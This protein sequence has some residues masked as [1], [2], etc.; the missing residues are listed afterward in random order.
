MAGE[1][2]TFIEEITRQWE[3]ERP[4]LDL[5]DFLL[6]I[7]LRRLGRLIESEYERLCQARSA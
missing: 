3:Q 4:D 6:A 5:G 1:P 7:Y 2:D